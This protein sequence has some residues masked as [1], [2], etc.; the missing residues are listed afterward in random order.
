MMA[1]AAVQ[2]LQY[3]V[4]PQRAAYPHLLVAFTSEKVAAGA[5]A[6]RTYIERSCGHGPPDFGTSA[7]GQ[8]KDLLFAECPA[9][10]ASFQR[11]QV[12]GRAGMLELEDTLR[13]TP[14]LDVDLGQASGPY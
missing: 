13:T 14:V 1:K 4:P 2:R 7:L 10:M 12:R 5:F 8:G 6:A 11:R 9:W 3:A